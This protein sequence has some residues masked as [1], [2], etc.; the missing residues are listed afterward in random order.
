[1]TLNHIHNIEHMLDRAIGF[2]RMFDRLHRVGQ[3]A[4][5]QGYPPYNILKTDETAYQIE[6]AVAG[7]HQDEIE[8]EVKEGTLI[9]NGKQGDSK[10]EGVEYLHKGIAGRSFSR[11]FTLSDDVVVKGADLQNGILFIFLEHVIPEEKKPRKIE[12]GNVS[13]K[14]LL[15]EDK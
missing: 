10:T 11:T 12:I 13:D 9:V 6:L 2:D 8:I 15:T 5:S 14:Q 7:F 3:S 1:M 4:P